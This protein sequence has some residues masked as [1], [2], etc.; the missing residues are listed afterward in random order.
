[1]G[2]LKD[3][4]IEKEGRY[5]EYYFVRDHYLDGNASL[6][7]VLDVLTAME[8]EGVELPEDEYI[9]QLYKQARMYL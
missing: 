1:M 7:D 4:L 2:R 9:V 5:P 3:V 6:L 8:D